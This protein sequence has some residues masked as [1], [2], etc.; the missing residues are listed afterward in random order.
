MHLGVTESLLSLPQIRQTQQAGSI[1]MFSIMDTLLF[2]MPKLK[3]VILMLSALKSI[4]DANAAE[5]RRQSVLQEMDKIA[6]ETVSEVYL[7]ALQSQ[8]GGM[9]RLAALSQTADTILQT[10]SRGSEIE[11]ENARVRKQIIDGVGEVKRKFVA[12]L[13][14]QSERFLQNQV[15][16]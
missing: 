14:T 9:A 16:L 6:G 10:L 4:R 13:Q 1:A 11:T 7:T 2:D 5:S 8:G 3:R 12:D 15:A